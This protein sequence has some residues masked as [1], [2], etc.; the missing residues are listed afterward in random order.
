MI[1]R[2][3]GSGFAAAR[4]FLAR[5]LLRLGVPPN[6]ITLLGGALT[7]GAGVCFALGASG[8]FAWSLRPGAGPSAFLLLAGGLLLLSAACDMLDGAVARLGGRKTE[9][10]GFLD[11]TL[12]RFSD[13]AVYAGLALYYA[14]APPRANLTFLLL[15][16]LAFFNA[17]LISYTKARAEDFIESCRVGFWQRGE[18]TAAVLIA[19][20]A[21]NIPA[22]L[23]QQAFLPALTVWRRVSH[24]RGEIRAKADP[25]ARQAKNRTLGALQIWRHPKGTLGY[26][27]TV[28]ANIAW[29]IFAPIP[30]T[31]VLRRWLGA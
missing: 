20:F 22:L 9:F 21:H 29:L 12:D 8:R 3:I 7:G 14:W 6:A 31:D 5:G 13:F 1:G 17:F 16:M 23:V 24:T 11:S 28:A 2:A 19:T 15:A 10:G 27:V 18:R 4:D 25:A 30:A 26:D